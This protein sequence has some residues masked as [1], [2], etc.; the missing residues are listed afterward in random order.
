MSDD[1]MPRPIQRPPWVLVITL[2]DDCPP[3]IAPERGLAVPPGSR[4][5][6][7]CGDL[8]ERV[9][10]TAEGPEQHPTAEG[11]GLPDD[12]SDPCQA[13]RDARQPDALA[14]RRSNARVIR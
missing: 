6:A 10:A 14:D 12:G 4:G 7:C 8:A 3:V 2:P 11:L 9:L 13:T 1:Q 5:T